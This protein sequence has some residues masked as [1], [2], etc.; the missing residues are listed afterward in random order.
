EFSLKTSPPQA[1]E[2]FLNSK[3]VIEC[4][5]SGDVKKEVEGATVSWTVGGRTQTSSITHGGVKQTGSAF[6]KTSTL[7]IT[8]SVWFSGEEVM[9]LASSGRKTISEKI[10]VRKGATRPSITIYKTDKSVRD[11]DTVSLV[12]EVS[13][14]DLGDVYIMWQENFGQYLEVKDANM[15]NDTQLRR[16][17]TLKT[18]FSLKISPPHVKELY[19]GRGA[20][21]KCVLSG[22]NRKVVEGATVSW[23][24]GGNPQTSGIT[25]GGVEQTG[26]AFT[27]TSTLS[28]PESVWFSGKEV[29]C[30]ASS[31]HKTTSEKISVRKVAT[32][33]S[34]TIYKPDESV[35]D[36]DT[37]SLVCEVSGSDVRNVSI[38]WQEN[39][40][41][42]LEGDSTATIQHGRTR[43]VLSTLTVTG[44]QYNSS[45]Y[46]CVVKDA[47]MENDPE[48]RKIITSKRKDSSHPSNSDE[49]PAIKR[50]NI[51]VHCMNL[52]FFLVIKNITEGSNYS[53][54]H[55]HLSSCYPSVTDLSE[56]VHHTGVSA[57]ISPPKIRLEE[58]GQ[59]IMCVIEGFY[60]KDLTIKWKK[61]DRE[62]RGLDW[63]TSTS[64]S[65]FYKA[66]SVLQ[67]D[68][69]S[70]SPGTIYTCEVTHAGSTYSEHMS[71]K[72]GFSLKISP[73]HVKELYMGRGAVIKCVL[74]GDNRKEVEGAT[75]SWSVGGNPQTSDIT[76]AG[77]DQTGSAF[78]KTSMLSIPES[79][80]FSGKEVIC[81]ASSG[82]KATSKKISFRKGAT[83]PSITIYKPDKSVS[84]SDTVSLVCEV[85]GSD[86][87]NVSI[88]WQENGGQYLEGDST[89][90]IQQGR[91]L[92]VLSY[93]TV[94]GQQ[95]NS[96]KY[97][98][99]VKDANLENDPELRTIT[100]K[101]KDSSHPCSASD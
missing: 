3:A 71:S 59:S 7:T 62:V 50:Q 55:A 37:V 41:Q 81:S 67:E 38:L 70:S 32:R 35:S 69:A 74:S 13:G 43:I 29:I 44:Q 21:I 4:V 20:V 11:S 73:P 17:T 53:I 84:D 63:K 68:V 101:R 42:Y 28:I 77:V 72:A 39:G 9:C 31:G 24:V 87:R 93:L 90:T 40:G 92:I 95:Y 25:L 18:E 78:T 76:L 26:S 16:V 98:C 34:I 36:T 1:K 75:V 6:T 51:P 52:K 65:G 58:F 45:K 22:D 47:N 83:R 49:N 15:E 12:C 27:K 54:N 60:P 79:V 96:S 91:T 97:T 33:P 48:L 66:V 80:W 46:T 100:S 85:S 14:S 99:V 57:G 82:H 86:V 8:E 61:D 94:T 56:G 10:R 19:M 88:L 5:I 89:A 2:L 30:S 23:S 64:D